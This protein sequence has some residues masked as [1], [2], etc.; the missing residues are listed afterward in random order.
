M[1]IMNNSDKPKVS[2]IDESKITP[3]DSYRKYDRLECV[4]LLRILK[5]ASSNLFIII[6]NFD[7]AHQILRETFYINC[8]EMGIYVIPDGVC[9]D[10]IENSEPKESGGDCIYTYDF[11]IASEFFVGTISVKTTEIFYVE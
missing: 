1:F 11:D 8:Y 4:K 9:R 2:T 6:W 3:K 10:V 7:D 5:T